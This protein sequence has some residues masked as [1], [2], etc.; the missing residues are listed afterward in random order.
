MR[1]RNSNQIKRNEA[2]NNPIMIQLLILPCK[3][4]K[5]SKQNQCNEHLTEATENYFYNICG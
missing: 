4:I 2:N 3:K 5:I 1:W